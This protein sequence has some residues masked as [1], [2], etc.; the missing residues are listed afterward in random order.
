MGEDKRDKRFGD[1]YVDHYKCSLSYGR[2]KRNR[3][4]FLNWTTELFGYLGEEIEEKILQQVSINNESSENDESIN[5]EVRKAVEKL[6]FVE[7]QFVEL[8]Y[9]ESKTYQEI[10]RTLKKKVYK[11]ERIHQRALGKL[12]ILLADFVKNR[13][14]LD[15]PQKTDCIICKSPFRQELDELIRNKKPEETYARLI[16]LFKQQYGI[17]IKTPQ[18]IIGHQ[19]KH[20]V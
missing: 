16:K 18:V 3:I 11:L 19:R 4:R 12:R 5:Q 20:M 10:A 2:K 7:K 14:K 6:S 8:F 17:D 15:V 1:H 9:F 13:F